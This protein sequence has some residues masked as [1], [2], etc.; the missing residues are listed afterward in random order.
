MNTQEKFTYFF[1]RFALFIVYVWFGAL[2]LIDASP[3]NP[4]VEQL[5][6][7]TLPFISFGEFIVIL[8]I[9]EIAIGVLFI[10]PRMER[11]A[12]V[13]L[14]PHMLV[15]I[16]PLFLLAP[17]TWTGMLSPTLEG[18]YIIKNILIIALG[19]DIFMES[20]K[21]RALRRG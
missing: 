3:A 5:L 4:L 7:K 16:A 18:Q 1:S 10:I 20:N 17:V 11:L 19:I 2:K 9:F 13:F 14:I 12:L 15:T 21:V 8:G 6:A